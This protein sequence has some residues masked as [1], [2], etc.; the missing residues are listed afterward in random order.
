MFVVSGTKAATLAAKMEFLEDLLGGCWGYKSTYW[1]KLYIQR[2][3]VYK[4]SSISSP[5]MGRAMILNESTGMYPSP[6]ATLLGLSLLHV[7]IH[8]GLSACEHMKIDFFF[9]FDK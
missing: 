1:K 9:Y 8:I 6:V 4:M 2:V 3:A 7:Y 5:A